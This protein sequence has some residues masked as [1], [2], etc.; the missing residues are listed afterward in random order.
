[1][2]KVS[3]IGNSSKSCEVLGWRPSILNRINIG[4]GRGR[5]ISGESGLRNITTFTSSSSDSIKS[6]SERCCDSVKE[7]HDEILEKLAS[8][9]DVEIE[10]WVR[11]HIGSKVKMCPVLRRATR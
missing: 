3:P 6:I 1:M 10:I 2:K 4:K 9:T 11:S 5:S 8:A 7:E